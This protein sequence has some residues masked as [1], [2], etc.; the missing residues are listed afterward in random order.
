MAPKKK[1]GAITHPSTLKALS[2]AAVDTTGAAVALDEAAAVSYAIGAGG[3][4]VVS[5]LA[6]AGARNAV[7]GQH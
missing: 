6:E 2:H 3:A 1:P 4:V 7:V 5:P